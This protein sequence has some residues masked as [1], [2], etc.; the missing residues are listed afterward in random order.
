[1]QHLDES[2]RYILDK[3]KE[4]RIFFLK[5]D[6][7][8]DYRKASEIFKILEDLLKHP[9]VL[10]MPNLLIT[11]ETNNGKTALV[12]KFYSKYKPHVEI[13]NNRI[14]GRAIY[15]QAPPIPDER[16]FY[17]ILLEELN[18][19]YSISDKLE[20]KRIQV[21]NAL[22]NLGTKMVI[23]D[24][25][26]HIQTGSLV[27]QKAFVNMLITLSD[28]LQI[29]IIAVGIFEAHSS[30]AITSQFS[31]RF[32]WISL[33]KWELNEDYFRLLENFAKF[34]PLHHPSTIQEPDIASKILKMSEGTIGEISKI[35]TIAGIKA[36][37]SE[38]EQI[39][40]H[41]LENINYLTPSNRRSYSS[42]F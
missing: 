13:E 10:R 6:K 7:W 17:N 34:L 39:D 8:F 29:V 31:N 37:I 42:F 25:I 16:R 26:H 14:S 18:I 32:D 4:D 15:V 27:K 3:S 11:A 33:P 2:V 1:M 38:T 24:E 12:R 28:L 35:L 40:R 23:I 19:S 5:C 9:P 30:F 21:L 22:Q 20:K 36:I 41:I